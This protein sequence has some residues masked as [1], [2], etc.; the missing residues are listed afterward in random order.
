MRSFWPNFSEEELELEVP[1][2]FVQNSA[3]LLISNYPERGISEKM[4]L[5]PGLSNGKISSENEAH[6]EMAYGTVFI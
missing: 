3:K 4:S 1:A 2:E 5:R 6:Q